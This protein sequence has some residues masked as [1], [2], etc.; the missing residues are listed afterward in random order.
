MKGIIGCYSFKGGTGRT[1]STANIAVALAQLGRNVLMVDLDIEGPGLSVVLEVEN[2]EDMCIQDYFRNRYYKN[3]DYTSLIID[4]KKRNVESGKKEWTELPG[5][6]F[7]I[8]ARIGTEKFS[9]V[10]TSEGEAYKRL[11]K[12]IERLKE[13]DYLKLDY[14][15]IDS[16]SGYGDMSAA[17][18]A[19]S[20]LLLAFFKWSRQ[21]TR[22]TI[23]AAKLFKQLEG[24]GAKID[25]EFIANSVPLTLYTDEYKEYLYL[26]RSGLE[27]AV[28]K[29]IFAM[30]PENDELKWEEKIILFSEE[31]KDRDLINKFEEVAANLVKKMEG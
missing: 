11:D 26:V 10:E 16:A 9:M 18:I 14:I 8:P 27:N 5:N 29:K 3:F 1:T 31:P 12:L 4:L 6:L 22:G 7:F 2:P 30:L 19:V 13:D 20:D 23:T 24:R 28:G 21:H 25:Y 15:L 17:T